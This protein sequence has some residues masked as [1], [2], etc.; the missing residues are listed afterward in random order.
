MSSA[1]RCALDD[2]SSKLVDSASFT[3]PERLTMT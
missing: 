2:S 3:V 1:V